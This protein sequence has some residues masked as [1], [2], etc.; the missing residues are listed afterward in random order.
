M[1]DRIRVTTPD[2][3]E[4]VWPGGFA[5]FR[6][7]ASDGTTRVGLPHVVSLRLGRAAGESFEINVEDVVAL[8]NPA[9]NR[10]L[11]LAPGSTDDPGP[12]MAPKEKN[13]LI[14]LLGD[15]AAGRASEAD[16]FRYSRELPWLER[17]A[18]GNWSDDPGAEENGWIDDP[19]AAAP[20][21]DDAGAEE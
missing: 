4:E 20:F 11:E 7:A 13:R 1:T 3:A 18:P 9:D 14:D 16:F 17:P 6:V 12:Q 8:W 5:G 21:T 2:S 19:G 15:V 10:W